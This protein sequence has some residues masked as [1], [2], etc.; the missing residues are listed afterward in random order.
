MLL[1]QTCD[2]PCGKPAVAKCADGS[3]ICSDCSVE[4]CGDS[5][6]GQC[7]EYNV[8]HSCLRKPVQNECSP[9][10]VFDTP[11]K[12]GSRSAAI[13][14]RMLH[15]F[16][17]SNTCGRPAANPVRICTFRPSLREP[18]QPKSNNSS[19]D[20]VAGCAVDGYHPQFRKMDC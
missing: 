2:T 10:P 5:F 19:S 11:D 9:Y 18:H 8:T 17:R 15:F 16:L 7:C 20:R 4:C 1:M 3:S 14:S 13:A 6:C 12:L